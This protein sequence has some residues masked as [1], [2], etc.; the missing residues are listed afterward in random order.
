MA[1]FDYLNYLASQS[2][3]YCDPTKN[4]SMSASQKIAQ[5]NN[6]TYK[7]NNGQYPDRLYR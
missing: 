3:I 5:A 6:E 7:K 4:L 2:K 1:N